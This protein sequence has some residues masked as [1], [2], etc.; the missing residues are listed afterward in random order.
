MA[1]RV[2]EDIMRPN[3]SNKVVRVFWSIESQEIFN[4]KV[5]IEKIPE[6]GFGEGN[7]FNFPVMDFVCEQVRVV[8]KVD[9]K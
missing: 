8:V 1:I 2:D 7:S 3:V 5:G 4:R 9:L 6:L